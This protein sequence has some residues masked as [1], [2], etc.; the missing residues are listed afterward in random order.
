[1]LALLGFLFGGISGIWY[2]ALFGATLFLFSPHISPQFLMRLYR[3][4]PLNP[5]EAED[6]Y[7]IITTLAKR[8]GLPAVPQLYYLPTRMMNAFA[9]GNRKNAV[10]A[11]TDGLLRRLDSRE[12]AGVLAHEISHI[13]HNDLRVMSIADVISRM[14]SLL[15]T[16]GQ[17]LL[18][19]NLPLLLMGQ[20]TISWLGIL[21]L[22]AAPTISSLMQLALSRTREFDADLGAVELT[23]DPDGLARA[24]QKLEYYQ[25]NLWQSVL[26]PGRR[27]PDPSILRTHPHTEERVRRL[28]ALKSEYQRFP[29]DNSFSDFSLPSHFT[30]IINQPR[31]HHL[32]G[33]WY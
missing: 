6:I 2:A 32:R 15:S 7:A 3:A 31:W 19:F 33:I 8:A 12:F 21:L 28:Q 24:L 14:T 5:Y 25:G 26:M 27:V 20:V 13:R 22:I 9:V 1:M 16:F 23:G 10:I 4:R 29:E 18:F 30:Q 11:V 17:L